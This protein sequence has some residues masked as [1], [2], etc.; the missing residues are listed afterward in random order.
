MQRRTLVTL[1]LSLLVAACQP[2]E[3]LVGEGSMFRRLSGGEFILH[4]DIS[5]RA[6]VAHTSF[7]DGAV[8]YGYN[9]FYPHCE[10]QV[11]EIGAEPQ[12]IPAGTYRIG[13]VLGITRYVTRPKAGIMLAAAGDFYLPVDDSGSEWYMF[14]YHMLLHSPTAPDGLTL[15]CGGA[16]NYPFYVKYPSLQEMLWSLGPYGT[17]NLP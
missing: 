16:Y 2:V 15:V 10:L 9:E 6:G 7:Q 11:A 17:I 4:R 1:L 13:R 5:I 3:R 8:A 12:T 14:A